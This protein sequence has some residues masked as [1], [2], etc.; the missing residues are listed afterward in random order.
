VKNSG[1]GSFYVPILANK[2]RPVDFLLYPNFGL[3]TYTSHSI[4]HSKYEVRLDGKR[5]Y[6]TARK[7]LPEMSLVSRFCEAP[8]GLC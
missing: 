8:L 7:Y 1:A 2:L 3:S 5:M 6:E 4:Y